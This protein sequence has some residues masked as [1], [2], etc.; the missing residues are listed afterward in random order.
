[1]IFDDSYTLEIVIIILLIVDIIISIV[2]IKFR[3]MTNQI[4]PIVI[5]IDQNDEK[6]NK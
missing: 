5:T 4:N 3:Y 1:M 2:D 6:D